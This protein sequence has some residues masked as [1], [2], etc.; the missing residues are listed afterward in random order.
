MVDDIGFVDTTIND[1]GSASELAEIA[2]RLRLCAGDN[3]QLL[4]AYN[5]IKVEVARLAGVPEDMYEHLDEVIA[6][7]V[8]T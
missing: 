6:R 5:L 7:Y 2:A 8:D 3:P 4:E 1:C